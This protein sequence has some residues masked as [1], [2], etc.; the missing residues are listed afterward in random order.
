MAARKSS[1]S[2][3]RR[4]RASQFQKKPPSFA[5]RPSASVRPP[6]PARWSFRISLS[7]RGRHSPSA[8]L[9]SLPT[10]L[11]LPYAILHR[12]TS[13]RATVTLKS[14][15]ASE[16]GTPSLSRVASLRGSDLMTDR[17]REEGE[18]VQEHRMQQERVAGQRNR[19][20]R[21]R[22]PFGGSVDV[23]RRATMPHSLTHDGWTRH[24]RTRHHSLT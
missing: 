3:S 10:P 22:S 16:R 24:A 18:E 9:P 15:R 4:S 21:R 1:R 20:R 11:P 19:A 6:A 8:S 17:G 14:E 5:L 13:D 12:R 23:T 7:F 2:S